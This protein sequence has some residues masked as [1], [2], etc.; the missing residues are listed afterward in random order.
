M[1]RETVRQASYKSREAVRQ[2]TRQERQSDRLTQLMCTTPV[3]AG[4]DA[5]I[6][7]GLKWMVLHHLVTY[8]VI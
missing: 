6:Y 1:S 5:Y 4:S 7:I 8:I 3:T 2:V